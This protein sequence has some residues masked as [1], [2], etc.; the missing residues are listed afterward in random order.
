MVA[1]PVAAAGLP[2]VDR[3][4]IIIANRRSIILR[5]P[6]RSAQ[7]PC[8]ESLNGCKP[9][10]ALVRERYDNLDQTRRNCWNSTRKLCH[11]R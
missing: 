9:Q 1:T 11:G 4:E 5:C 7:R 8:P 6:D 3:R 2:V 10:R